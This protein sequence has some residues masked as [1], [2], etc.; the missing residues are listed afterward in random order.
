MM[1]SFI[2][3]YLYLNC[4]QQLQYHICIDDCKFVN[5]VSSPVPA[6]E[7]SVL[8]L[9]IPLIYIFPLLRHDYTKL[10][11][12]WS[13]ILRYDSIDIESSYL[14]MLWCVAS[15]F[16]FLILILSA[17]LGCCTKSSHIQI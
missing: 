17:L 13:M 6:C 11:F 2:N 10:M 1:A 9:I 12:R 8:P 5:D 7:N 4:L 16:I 15:I 3:A 14:S